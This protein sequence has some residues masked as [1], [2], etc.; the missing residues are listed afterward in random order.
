M[1][2]KIYCKCFGKFPHAE[3]QFS[4]ICR[5]Y[6]YERI[7][8]VAGAVY[9]CRIKVILASAVAEACG[10]VETAGG[11]KTPQGISGVLRQ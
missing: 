5:F 6:R 2:F 1:P 9:I 8:G 11:E 3:V 10:I 7:Y 4:L